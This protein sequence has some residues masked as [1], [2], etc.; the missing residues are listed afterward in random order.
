MKGTQMNEQ[1]KKYEDYKIENHKYKSIQVFNELVEEIKLLQQNL[2][3]S[4][5]YSH[6]I[7][8]VEKIIVNEEIIAKKKN[9]VYNK[10][11]QNIIGR[12]LSRIFLIMPHHL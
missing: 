8:V 12:V 5:E 7:L 4:S 1:V 11:E 9:E 3:K 2:Y 10:E 6:H